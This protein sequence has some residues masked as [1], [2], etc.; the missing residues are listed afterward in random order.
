[1]ETLTF[2]ENTKTIIDPT[3]HKFLYVLIK[4]IFFGKDG[5]KKETFDHLV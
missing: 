1:M 3:V 2:F 4:Y 5:I